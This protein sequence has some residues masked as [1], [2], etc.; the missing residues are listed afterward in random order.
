MAS[1]KGLIVE[2]WHAVYSETSMRLPWSLDLSHRKTR[3]LHPKS[4]GKAQ[5][6]F[7]K[8]IPSSWLQISSRSASGWARAI[9]V[10]RQSR[11]DKPKPTEFAPA[12]VG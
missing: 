11:R 3:P 1:L 8:A 2:R 12:M 7:Q 4:N 6:A 9:W 10:D 5:E